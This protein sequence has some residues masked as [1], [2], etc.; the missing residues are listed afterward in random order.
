M[1]WSVQWVVPP[2]TERPIM[3]VVLSCRL[4]LT[5]CNTSVAVHPHFC[6]ATL[7]CKIYLMELTTFPFAIPIDN[8]GSSCLIHQ[9]WKSTL[10]VWL[11]LVGAMWLP[12]EVVM[13]EFAFGTFQQGI[14][15]RFLIMKV[16]FLQSHPKH[17]VNWLVSR[18]CCASSSCQWPFISSPLCQFWYS[19]RHTTLRNLAILPVE[20]LPLL[21]Y[22]R[23]GLVSDQIMCTV[24]IIKSLAPVSDTVGAAKLTPKDHFVGLVEQWHVSCLMLLVTVIQW[25]LEDQLWNNS[26][27]VWLLF[28]IGC[29]V[30]T[31]SPS[32]DGPPP[33]HQDNREYHCK[34]LTRRM[35]TVFWLFPSIG[36]YGPW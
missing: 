12:V 14:F 30:H 8:Q 15:S 24:T 26:H 4:K 9:C 33:H 32:N 5:S 11:S 10:P 19:Y 36:S 16:W 2:V 35:L 6:Q 34:S 22:G 1:S 17:S 13:A 27:F 18:F 29:H 3:Y 7:L 31:C 20:D 28:Y 21:R 23:L 25:F